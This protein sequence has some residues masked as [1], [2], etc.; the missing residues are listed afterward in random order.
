MLLA[1]EYPSG[2]FG[3]GLLYKPVAMAPWLADYDCLPRVRRAGAGWTSGA[4]S[5]NLGLQCGVGHTPSPEPAQ[6]SLEYS[7]YFLGL[8][9]P[10]PAVRCWLRGIPAWPSRC[11]AC[12]LNSGSRRQHFAFAAEAEQRN[13]EMPLRRACDV[14]FSAQ[15]DRSSLVRSKLTAMVAART[16][17][18]WS[19]LLID[20]DLPWASP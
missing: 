17:P 20:P 12:A 3:V 10:V 5:T 11:L 14:E 19:S 13:L 6:M 18:A 2:F 7:R 15:G 4:G 1:V 16:V 9:G 8:Q